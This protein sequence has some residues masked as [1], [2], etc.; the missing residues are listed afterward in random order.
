MWTVS[1]S[2]QKPNIKTTQGGILPSSVYRVFVAQRTK[3]VLNGVMTTSQT[4]L[5][6]WLVI[7]ITRM[8]KRRLSVAASRGG[9]GMGGIFPQSE[10]FPLTP[11]QEKKVK[12]SH[13]GNFFDFCPLR[14]VFCPLDA[15]PKKILVLRLKVVDSKQKPT[16]AFFILVILIS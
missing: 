10:A 9:G 2:Q 6:L 15:P 14:N 13:F 16:G 4:F 7:R 3:V 8:K 11:H 5:G 12:I 1:R